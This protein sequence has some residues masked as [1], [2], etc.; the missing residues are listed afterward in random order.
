MPCWDDQIQPSYAAT[1]CDAM[2][3]YDPFFQM[4]SGRIRALSGVFA[5]NPLANPSM[6]TRV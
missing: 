3:V 5:I 4:V 2:D 6:L 1:P